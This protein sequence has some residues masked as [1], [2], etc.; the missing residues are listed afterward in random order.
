MR[1]LHAQRT[2]LAVLIGGGTVFAAP[3]ALASNP[4]EYPDNG[5]AAFSRGGAWLAVG[6][7]PI[8]AH[9]NPAALATQ[10]SGFSIEQQ[11]NFDKV[12][13]TRESPGGGPAGPAPAS[14]DSSRRRICRRARIAGLSRAPFRPSR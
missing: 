8:A 12:C 6:N 3:R 1:T 4:L 7:E 14:S 2:I 5:A 11:L 10:G 9:Y 13:F